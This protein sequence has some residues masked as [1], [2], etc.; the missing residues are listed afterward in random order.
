M[1]KTTEEDAH[2]IL[3]NALQVSRDSGEWLQQIS[4]PYYRVWVH[5]SAG[6]VA[7]VNITYYDGKISAGDIV[8]LFGVPCTIFVQGN[9]LF[10]IYPNAWF[11]VSRK[12]FLRLRVDTQVEEITLFDAN[13]NKQACDSPD[14]WR[15]FRFY[16]TRVQ[17]P[18]S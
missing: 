15:G 11:I 3:D 5:A 9:Q 10:L 2:S 1:G 7:G 13:R 6:I 14:Q 8:N 4:K 18:I 12:E 16:L 17:H